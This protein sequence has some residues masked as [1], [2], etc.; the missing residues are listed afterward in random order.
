MLWSWIL[1]GGVTYKNVHERLKARGFVVYQGQGDLGKQMFRIAH[2]GDITNADL[3]R[4]G[5][6]LQ[7]CFGAS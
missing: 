3:D 4:L 6:A 2:M 1:A 7:D 5:D